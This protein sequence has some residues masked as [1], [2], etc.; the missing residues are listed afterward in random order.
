VVLHSIENPLTRSDSFFEMFL[1]IL[2]IAKSS[3][4]DMNFEVRKRG[5]RVTE[6]E[7]GG[8]KKALE[9]KVSLRFS[10]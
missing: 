2:A 10:P 8:W 6:R 3:E 1:C 9:L 4:Y 7:T 5:V